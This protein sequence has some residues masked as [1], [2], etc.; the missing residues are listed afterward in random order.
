MLK[1]LLGEFLGTFGLVFCGTGAI[2]INQESNGAITHLGIAITFGLI[3]MTMILS[4]GHISGAHINPAVTIA[5]SVSKRF[6]RQHIAPYIFAQI[7]GALFASYILHYLF[8]AN[9]LLGAT[10]P[11]GSDIQSCVLEFILTFLLM[12]V[13]LTST[14][15]KDHS[16]LGPAL[17][18]GGTVGLEALFAGPICG[19]SMN[20]ARSLSPALIGGHYRSVWV[21]IIGPLIGALAGSFVFAILNKDYKIDKKSAT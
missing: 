19:A 12:I 16:L 8:P 21:Y 6:K 1:R 9:E 17:A 20:P 15:K 3:V 7:G 18:I 14:Q 13:I 4:F 11:R 5:L 2:I 10:I